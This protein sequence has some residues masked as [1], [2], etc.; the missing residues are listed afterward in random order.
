MYSKYLDESYYNDLL[1]VLDMVMQFQ[2]LDVTRYHIKELH[3]K[4]E[5]R[6]AM[7]FWYDK[8][9]SESLAHDVPSNLV[10]VDYHAVGQWTRAF[11]LWCYFANKGERLIV[12][13]RTMFSMLRDLNDRAFYPVITEMLHY[14]GLQISHYK[15][16]GQ[17]K[18]AP[19]RFRVLCDFYIYFLTDLVLNNLGSLL[20]TMTDHR[21]LM[22]A[23]IRNSL[24]A[25]PLYDSI[26]QG[27]VSLTWILTEE[28]KAQ[29]KWLV[30]DPIHSQSSFYAPVRIT[31]LSGRVIPTTATMDTELASDWHHVHD[32]IA[33]DL[34][35]SGGFY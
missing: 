6:Q 31:S 13:K 1:A 2:T 15:S 32:W 5:L 4:T 22:S 30:R 18:D 10:D 20:A 25:K 16:Q 8:I 29:L 24:T 28:N 35:R 7:E 33:G 9:A 23:Q 21:L 12:V 11:V 17:G 3:I 34:Y 27:D 26:V 14:L 19:I